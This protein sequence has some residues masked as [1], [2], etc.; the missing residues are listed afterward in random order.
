MSFTEL[1]M[2]MVRLTQ[3][4]MEEMDW[5]Y[6]EMYQKLSAYQNLPKLTIIEGYPGSPLGHDS[7]DAT[8]VQDDY[9]RGYKDATTYLTDGVVKSFNA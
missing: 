4:V 2:N 6:L 9:N 5:T 1:G 7:L 8:H 3:D